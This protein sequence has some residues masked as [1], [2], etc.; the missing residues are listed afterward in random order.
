MQGSGLKE[1]N[2]LCYE[3]NEEFFLLMQNLAEIGRMRQNLAEIGR[4]R[5]N[6]RGV[7]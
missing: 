5:Q 3:T 4:I 7:D 1:V 2:D 6:G